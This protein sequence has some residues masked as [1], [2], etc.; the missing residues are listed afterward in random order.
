MTTSELSPVRI[1]IVDDH[2]LVREGMA[3]RIATQ[4]NWVVCGQS[5]TIAGALA[6]VGATA[7]DVMIVDISLKDGNGLELIRQLSLRHEKVKILVISAVQDSL[8]AERALRAGALGYLNKQETNEKMIQA[9]RTVAAGQRFIPPE[10]ARRMKDASSQSSEDRRG[11]ERLSNRELE[12]FRLIGEGQTASAIAAKLSISTN[13]ID[14]H[15]ENIKRKLG[16]KDA[17]E[18]NRLAVQ[19]VL[20]NA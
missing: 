15:R 3:V 14:S 1:H 2:P 6:S 5:D 11:V 7:P 9:I 20:E 16:A 10:I 4:S 12:V 8:Y 13:T 18:L 19:W 17:G